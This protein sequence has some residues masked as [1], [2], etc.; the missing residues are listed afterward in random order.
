MTAMRL[1][2]RI[3]VP[4]AWLRAW[5][6]LSSR[7]RRFAFSAVAVVLLAAGWGLVWQPMQEDTERAREE[8]L[9]DRAA[10]AVAR[11]QAAEMAGL[12][13]TA[14][15]SGG[16]PRLAIERVLAERSL[17][18]TVTSL[19]IKDNRAY[20]T[21]GAIGFDALVGA[22]DALAKADGLRAVEAT[23]TA[24][25]DPGTVRAELTLAR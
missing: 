11:A 13:R 15:A 9:R 16:D 6:S 22:L 12:Q 21:F 10:L 5:D 20:V 2:Q 14:A 8:G 25:V 3:P 23:L 4:P 18:A 17:K 19:E 24:R 1:L 7:E